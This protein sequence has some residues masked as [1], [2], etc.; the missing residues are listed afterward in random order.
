MFIMVSSDDRVP[1]GLNG[2]QVEK[3]SPA[4]FIEKASSEDGLSLDEGL[5]YDISDMSQE[6]YEALEQFREITTIIYYYYTD[7]PQP[8][9]PISAEVIMYDVTP[10]V[11]EA[12]TPIV[13]QAP[14][15]APTPVVAPEPQPAPAPTPVV[16]PTPVVEQTPQPVPTPAPVPAPTPVATPQPAA[17]PTVAPTTASQLTPSQVMNMQRVKL[18]NMNNLLSFDEY[19]AESNVNERISKPAKVVLFGSSKGGSGK[20]FTCLI[21]AYWYAK[22]HPTEKVALADFDIIDGQVG[23][24][25]NNISPT[26]YD[27]YTNYKAGNRTFAYLKNCKV[28][29][30]YFS[31]NIDFY[32]P[33]AQDIPEITN[34]TDFWTDIFG[35]LIKNYD[36][37]FFDSGIDY[38]G[39][40]PIS[41]LYKIADKI[42]ITSNPTVNSV[43]SVIKQLKTLNG[44]RV[45][46]TYRHADNI[47]PKVNII[48]TRVDKSDEDDEELNS[49]V[50]D[51]LSGKNIADFKNNPIPIIAQFGQIDKT[52]KRVQWY[53][54]WEA[55]D[56]KD[57]I[58]D[59]LARICENIE[60]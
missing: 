5:W 48:L 41:N 55:I 13:E 38:I 47:I 52:I 9:F 43:R 10:K 35:H 29:S 39:N 58:T 4:E 20:T 42:Y 14:Q 27:Y 50:L 23:S 34:D 18:N 12:P 21:S 15:P 45:N 8:N 57:E 46:N 49:M 33:P 26:M 17:Q 40:K 6:V 25:L 19:D 24:V 16:T 1:E 51:N 7:R 54:D 22:T 30:S 44:T 37:V 2:F 11:E 31:P 53:Q 3:W 59:E 36:V 32:L 60:Q 28:S 56:A